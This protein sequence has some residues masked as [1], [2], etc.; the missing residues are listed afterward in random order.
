MSV[1]TASFAVLSALV[2]AAGL[3]A[4]ADA[5]AS[6]EPLFVVPEIQT[7]RL[8]SVHVNQE[9][10]VH[11]GVPV[12][13]RDGSER[14]PVL[15]MTDS[16]GGLSFA[17]ET[18]LMQALGDL[19]SFI[20][21]G[22]GYPGENLLSGMRVRWRDLTQAEYSG[23]LI[24]DVWDAVVPGVL[25]ATD[26]ASGG[27]PEF[28]R[29]LRDELVPFIDANYPTV[30][31][32]RGYWGDSLGGLFGLYAMLTEPDVFNRYIIGS[33]SIWWNDELLL[34]KAEE[35]IAHND[36]LH[37]KVFMAV[38]GLEELAGEDAAFRMVTNVGRLER[39]LRDADLDGLELSTHVFGDETHLTVF[40]LNYYRGVQMVYGRGRNIFEA[41]SEQ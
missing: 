19:K 11:V 7:H 20:M 13:R 38:G 26:K 12:S 9:F 35:F 23:E 40:P 34:Q 21:V 22:I 15:Y 17:E 31:G 28:L 24:P 30:P 39:M 18:R 5:R 37:A 33:P 6:Q 14:F 27:A 36:E 32:D 1:R 2:L 3:G 29:F 8:H 25:A 41:L 10:E 4:V 16:Q